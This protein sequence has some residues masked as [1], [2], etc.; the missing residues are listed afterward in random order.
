MTSTR[1]LPDNPV[2]LSRLFGLS[3][4][5]SKPLEAAG[6]GRGFVPTAGRVELDE[7]QRAH[8]HIKGAAQGLITQVIPAHET[9][10]SQEILERRILLVL[11]GLF[12]VWCN[13]Y[14]GSR[15]CRGC[16]AGIC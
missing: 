13:V 5:N 9:E 14:F 16:Y 11:N 10:P 4:V 12:K 8:W 15:N 7:H 2:C 1:Q 6:I 3:S